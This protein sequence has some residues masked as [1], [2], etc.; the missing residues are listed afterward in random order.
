MTVTEQGHEKWRLRIEELRHST[1]VPSVMDI[2]GA[3]QAIRNAPD[4]SITDAMLQINNNWLCGARYDA[5]LAHLLREGFVSPK[6]FGIFTIDRRK[7]PYE[8]SGYVLNVPKVS[9]GPP[10]QATFKPSTVK[11]SSEPPPTQ[12]EL[13]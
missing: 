1:A 12:W 9:S 4:N 10:P 11:P 5:V 7:L 3:Q 13:F 6:A 2:E 8:D